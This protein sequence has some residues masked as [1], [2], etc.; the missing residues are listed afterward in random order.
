MLLCVVHSFL[1]TVLHANMT[2]V[3][4]LRE[5]LRGAVLRRVKSDVLIGLALKAEL[6]VPVCMSALQ[7]SL[8][9]AILVKDISALNGSFKVCLSVCLSVCLPVCLCVCLSVCLSVCVTI[10]CV[11]C[12]GWLLHRIAKV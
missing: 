10:L 6:Y 8:Y 1:L 12:G 7:Q 2:Q 3:D 11:H 5:V 9:K 4:Q